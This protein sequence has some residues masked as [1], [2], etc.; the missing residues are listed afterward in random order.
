MINNIMTARINIFFATILFLLYESLNAQIK[1]DTLF[2]V[3]ENTIYSK[4]H[5]EK[6][7]NGIYKYIDSSV[8]TLNYY[9]TRS[10]GLPLFD[11][12]DSINLQSIFCHAISIDSFINAFNSAIYFYNLF[13]YDKAIVTFES[14]LLNCPPIDGKLSEIIAACYN[15]IGLC[16]I[17]LNEYKKSYVYL[18]KSLEIRL[19]LASRDSNKL[20]NIYNNLGLLSFEESKYSEAFQYFIKSAHIISPLIHK[21]KFKYAIIQL[22]LGACFQAI[23]IYDKAYYYYRQSYYI[24]DLFTVKDIVYDAKLHYNMAVTY[25][26]IGDPKNC[27]NYL[28][29]SLS[30][31]S[32][33]NTESMSTEYIDII[34]NI[35]LLK[36]ISYINL[37]VLSGDSSYLYHSNQIFEEANEANDIYSNKLEDINSIEIS[38]YLKVL[39]GQEIKKNYYLFEITDSIVYLNK[40]FSISEKLHHNSLFN[41]IVFPRD[42]RSDLLSNNEYRKD[43][44]LKY[45]INELSRKINEHILNDKYLYNYELINMHLELYSLNKE[46]KTLM[47]LY[48][49]NSNYTPIA[50]IISPNQLDISKLQNLLCDNQT[51]IEY[52]IFGQ[53][54]HAFIINK[55]NFIQFPLSVPNGTPNHYDDTALSYISTLNILSPSKS[56]F[57][58][59]NKEKSEQFVNISN[60]IYNTFVKPFIKYLKNEI[61]I[62]ADNNLNYIPFETLLME[63][64][65]SIN[66]FKTYKFFGDEY[67]LSYALSARTWLDN[68]TIQQGLAQNKVLGFAPFTNESA[69]KFVLSNT[70]TL[71][72]RDSITKLPESGRELD[73]LSQL[74]PG[75]YFKG[76][77]A[78]INNFHKLATFYSIIHL[79]THSR[80]NIDNSLNSWIAFADTASNQGKYFDKLYL[81]DIYNLNLNAN[82]VTLSSCESS[83]GRFIPGEGIISLSRAFTLA[84]AK[85][86]L[87]TLWKIE[88]KSSQRIMSLFYKNLH[89][90]QAKNIALWNAKKSYINENINTPFCHPYFW[91]SFILFGNVQSIY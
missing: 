91:S 19:D 45:R 36:S 10:Q 2:N 54:V 24:Y 37:Y 6:E 44:K 7:L 1:I 62:I 83:I 66:D 13:K 56:L 27:L 53:I 42:I 31:V 68:L 48:K 71:N 84:G 14:I 35:L 39:L 63:R 89:E 9:G 8:S 69:N 26:E 72:Y 80:S 43:K 46:Y 4:Q 58:F 90:G 50:K 57:N 30:I 74:F 47:S 12:I 3:D 65:S 40:N 22:N 87:S 28:Q 20:I 75:D 5:I 49:T 81:E 29:K 21:F 61:I 60:Y 16:Y 86:V 67:V 59:Y 77:F 23:K 17:R 34:K 15:N 25:Y 33:E 76:K 88:D 18:N 52:I 41:S 11:T 38:K 82:L 79:S 73:Q 78:N 51:M 70:V 32:Y 64:P 55:D 85:S